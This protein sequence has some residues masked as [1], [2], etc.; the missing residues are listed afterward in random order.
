MPNVSVIIP[1]YNRAKL[2]KRAVDSVLAQTYNDY[3]IIII[4]DGSTDGTQDILKDYHHSIRYI[5][6]ENEGI[7]ATRNRGIKE[8]K[9]KYLA[10]LDSDDQWFPDKLA[11]QVN[12]MEKN[13][14]LGIVCSK[15]NIL[16][17]KGE[18]IGTKPEQKTGKNFRELLE[19]GGDLPTSTVMA[20]KECFDK[21]GVF[22]ELL[23]PMEDFEMWVRIASQYDIYTVP[24]KVFALYYRHDEQITSDKFKVY[25]GTVKLQKKFIK[26]FKHKPE[27]PAKAVKNKLALF[28]YV[29]SRM[30]YKDGRFNEAFS[31]LRE[32]MANCPVIGAQ[33]FED[34]DSLAEKI[35]KLIKPCGYFPV[36]FIRKILSPQKR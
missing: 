16:N 13:H 20:R 25:E 12:L 36:C 30:Y 33:F 34:K 21:V 32:A 11:V 18:K 3:E 5:Y 24:D 19:I 2:I 15:M 27:F 23:P 4:D 9:G 17:G 14:N 28:A 6:K 22:D 35:I 29:L 1:T 10:F 31:T 7:S 8:A 26:L